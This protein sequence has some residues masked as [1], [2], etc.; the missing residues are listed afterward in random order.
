MDPRNADRT[1]ADECQIVDAPPYTF[2]VMEYCSRGELFDLI[3]SR[4]RVQ[5]P[6]AKV[7]FA[8]IVDAV[9]VRAKERKWGKKGGRRDGRDDDDDDEK[10]E[11]KKE[12]K[13]ERRRWQDGK[14]EMQE[15]EKK[16]KKKLSEVSYP[17]FL[18]FSLFSAGVPQKQ[19]CAPVH[20]RI[21]IA[22]M[23]L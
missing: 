9:A 13:K 22:N 3:V 18:F 17:L 19:F 5:E 2:L 21:T 14:K 10:K 20:V 4:K 15:E 16:T 8:Q 7:L 11:E 6:D 12:G 23:L 1:V